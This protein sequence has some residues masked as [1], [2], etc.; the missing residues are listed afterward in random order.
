MYKYALSFYYLYMSRLKQP[1]DMLSW[2]LIFLIPPFF[3]G[4]YG[5]PL[6]F[7]EYLLRFS[8]GF[9]AFY[10]LYEV[11]YLENDIITT[12]KESSATLRLP[13]KEQE[14][15]TKGYSQIVGFRLL[16]VLFF[17]LLLRGVVG[18][19]EALSAFLLL[20]L[21]SRVVFWF[22]NHL[23]NRGNI[24]TYFLLASLKY[25]MVF[26]LNG[27][28]EEGL[29]LLG[30]LL[31]FPL[32]RTLEHMARKRYGFKRY[33]LRMGSY[34][35]FRIVY[36]GGFV[37]I[38]LIPLLS[39][40]MSGRWWLLEGF[41][42]YFLLFRLGAYGLLRRGYYKRDSLKMQDSFHKREVC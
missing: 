12:Q 24:V 39:S 29:F 38:L 34:D 10:T 4:W 30:V 36:Y 3:L 1:I 18:S 8:L 41:G 19:W 35:C 37:F 31:L 9:M 14:K 25:G 20:L 27:T 26:T 16:L 40:E 5:T 13:F 17:L 15:I 2:I 32:P 11:G 22:H 23:R 21:V 28:Q 7:G 42:V 6:L 33:A